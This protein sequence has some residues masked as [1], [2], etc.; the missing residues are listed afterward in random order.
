MSGHKIPIG[1]GVAQAIEYV[2]QHW[3]DMRPTSV[4][5]RIQSAAALNDTPQGEEQGS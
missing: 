1:D 5:E 3:R 4:V 2:E